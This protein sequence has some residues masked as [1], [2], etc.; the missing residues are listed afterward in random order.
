MDGSP[1][2]YYYC[3]RT[4][5]DDAK[6]RSLQLYVLDRIGSVKE[7]RRSLGATMIE[8][9]GDQKIN[10]RHGVFSLHIVAER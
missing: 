9:D 10:K 7:Y 2:T 1:C 8:E 6:Q 3:R 4:A 5:P